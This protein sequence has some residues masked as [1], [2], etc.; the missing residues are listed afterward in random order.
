MDELMKEVAYA[1]GT[2]AH[3]QRAER[4]CGLLYKR[5]LSAV[6]RMNRLMSW[7]CRARLGREDLAVKMEKM[8]AR[9]VVS[10]GCHGWES[11]RLDAR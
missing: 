6:G 5:K 7:V 1:L 10:R 8:E 11:S 3:S 9:V 2:I 4:S